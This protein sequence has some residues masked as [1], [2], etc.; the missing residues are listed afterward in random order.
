MNLPAEQDVP[1]AQDLPRLRESIELCN[2]TFAYAGADRPA[3]QDVDLTIRAG[4]T[5]A[6]V[7][8]NGSG[9][10][11]LSNL[12]L[13]F[14]EPSGGQVRFDGR[15]IRQATLASVRKQIGLVTQDTVIF[16]DTIFNN[17]AYA[18]PK[19]SPERVQAAS[20]AAH[21]DEFIRLVRSERKGQEQTGYEAIVTS[22]TLSGGQKQR[23]AI[24]RAILNDPA[25]L[26][27]DE[28]T[29]QVDADSEKKIQEA[30]AE[31]TRG[32]TT[33]IIAHRLSTVIDA[34]RIVVMDKGRIVGAGTH[35]ELLDACPQYR[36]FCEA[37]LQ[38]A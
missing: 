6:L 18:D 34:D 13:R 19:A 15:D 29:S 38:V 21:A 16:T 25:I 36:T 30:L 4:E 31:V 14:F 22:R 23:I 9:K 1:G 28:A 35:Q 7:G 17:I 32:R 33:L 5:V 20:R 11:T 24:A 2:V 10:T 37:Q 3:I 12:L 8:P 27:F 26:I